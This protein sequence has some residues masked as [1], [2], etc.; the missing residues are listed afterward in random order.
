MLLKTSGEVRYYQ[1]ESLQHADLVQAVFT[2]RGGVSPAPYES[3]NLSISTGDARDNVAANRR[4]AFRALGRDPESI[5]DLWQ[6]HSAGVVV[7][8]KPV[9]ENGVSPKADALVTDQPRVTLLLRFADC[10]P[11][12]L[13]DPVRRAVA[14]VHAGWRGTLLKAPA[15]AVRAMSERYGSRPADL[16]AGIGPSIG[17][18]HYAVG[19]EVVEQTRT[20]FGGEADHLLIP[21]QQYHLD[22]WAANALALRQAGVEQIE[23]SR[24]CTACRTDEFFS[25]RGEQASTGRF[26]GLIALRSS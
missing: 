20:A 16:L 9:G 14:V 4:R 17:P 15:A 1:F 19:P 3:L 21:N 13:F 24:M 26:G 23:V 8:D 11:I 5:A 22:L 25:H 2:R 7:V 10:V 6:V 12:F 18:C